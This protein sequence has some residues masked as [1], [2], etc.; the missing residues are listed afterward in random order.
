MNGKDRGIYGRNIRVFERD[1]TA[2]CRSIIISLSPKEEILPWLKIFITHI[3]SKATLTIFSKFETEIE[4]SW[5]KRNVTNTHDWKI[6]N[7]KL[8]ELKSVEDAVL[9]SIGSIEDEIKDQICSS[10]LIE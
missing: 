10:I 4:S 9:S 7:C 5:T 3:F 1:I 2:P 6:T 8:K